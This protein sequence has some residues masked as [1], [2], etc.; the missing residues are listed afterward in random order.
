MLLLVLEPKVMVGFAVYPVAT[1]PTT[2]FTKSKL[3]FLELVLSVPNNA[4]FLPA[5][6][7]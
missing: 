6:F 2:P 7:T 5:L 1:L 3:T 4:Q